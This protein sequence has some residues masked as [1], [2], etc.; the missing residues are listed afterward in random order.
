MGFFGE[1]CVAKVLGIEVNN[2]VLIG[3]DV[4]YDL[5]YGGLTIQVKTSKTSLFF[6]SK[7]QMPR[8]VDVGALVQYAGENLA[9]PHKDPRFLVHGWCSRKDFENHHQVREVGPHGASYYCSAIHLR[10]MHDLTRYVARSPIG[11][12]VR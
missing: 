4:G 1:A 10:P 12:Y 11:N 8:N 9:N 2:D 7:P 6:L 3:G 5:S